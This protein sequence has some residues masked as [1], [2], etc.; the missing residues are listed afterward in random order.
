MVP[1]LVCQR[2]DMEGWRDMRTIKLR[3]L[4][5]VVIVMML[6][7]W[8]STTVHATLSISPAY[9]ELALDKG[10]P[11]GQF[12]ITNVGDSEERYRIKAIHFLFLEDGGFREIPP[13]DRS[14][15]QWV[16]F[17][18]KEFVLPP[19][20][21]Q[22]VRF[23][24]NTRGKLQTGEYWG[25]ME[26]ESLKTT[27]G[28][29]KDAAGRELSIEVIPTILVPIFGKVGTVRYQATLK[30]TR[31]VTSE[32][33]EIVESQ[34]A[35]T[36]QG[37]LF[38]GGTYE[39]ADSSGQSVASGILGRAY[40]LPGAERKFAVPLAVPLLAGQYI[41]RVEYS[42]TGLE[43]PMFRETTLTRTP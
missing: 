21:R 31:I 25:A 14:L 32:K 6:L 13:D 2:T 20:S 8:G 7:L 18:P 3:S 4:S 43:A 12:Q 37:R 40:V 33:G 17:N 26:L 22:T 19:K 5:A 35:N 24:V 39:I 1:A 29:G 34:I 30:E 38:I 9:V 11:S 16:R 36:G 27:H 23:T 10:R 15:A 41:L 42:S 28:R